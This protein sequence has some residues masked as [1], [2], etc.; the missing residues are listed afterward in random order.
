MIAR[1]GQIDASLFGVTHFQ[2]DTP[3]DV[4]TLPSGAVGFVQ[5]GTERRRPR[6]RGRRTDLADGKV[7]VAGDVNPRRNLLADFDMI[8]VVDGASGDLSGVLANSF[9]EFAEFRSPSDTPLDA[10]KPQPQLHLAGERADVDPRR[11]AQ[12]AR[13]RS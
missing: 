4:A 1:A 10:R 11:L 3:I 12:S 6:R 13:A 9:P 7:H 5:G 2:G 8:G